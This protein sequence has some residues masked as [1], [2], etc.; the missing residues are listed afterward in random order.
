MPETAKNTPANAKHEPE[1]TLTI[2]FV[3][4]CAFVAHGN[5]KKPDKVT[6]LLIDTDKAAPNDGLCRHD[7]LLLVRA[8][9]LIAGVGSDEGRFASVFPSDEYCKPSEQNIGLFGLRGKELRLENLLSASKSSVEPCDS[10]YNVLSLDKLTRRTAKVQA[11]W[12]DGTIKHGV[13]A[14]L[15]ITQG[16]LFGVRESDEWALARP[17]SDPGDCWITFQQIVRWEVCTQPKDAAGYWT[18][19]LGQNES[20]EL[21]NPA[22]LVISNLCPLDGQVAAVAPDILAFY[23][24][25]EDFVKPDHRRVLHRRYGARGDDSPERPGSEACP[26]VTGW[27]E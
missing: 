6:V 9:D 17:D 2:D 15:E 27:V 7:P 10:Y 8:E 26:P 21:K 18:L 23:A 24:M 5:P 16:K 13:A 4:L 19:L 14:R 11:D 25:A 20:L 3:G 12:V 1:P 22:H